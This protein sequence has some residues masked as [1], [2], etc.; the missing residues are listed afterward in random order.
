VSGNVSLYNETDGQP[1]PP[2]PV[3]G[4][5]G[6][7]E[8]VRLVPGRWQPGDAVLLAVAPE[9]SL[10][11]EA[12]LIRF[13]WQAAPL[14]TLCHDVGAAGLE[15]ALAEAARWSGCEA[16]VDV[17]EEPATGAALLAAPPDQVRRLGSRGFVQ[18]GE[19]P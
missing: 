4:C 1:I 16:D 18:I 7:V 15:A 14:L 6:L 13:L 3:V 17:P 5:V 12:A 19:V 10:A 11:A 2:T 8:D 9:A